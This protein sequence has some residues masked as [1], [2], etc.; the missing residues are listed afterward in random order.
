MRKDA[1]L[2]ELDYGKFRQS[3]RGLRNDR[4]F[5]QSGHRP[6]PTP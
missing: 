3:L 4:R 2:T 5:L 6:A 1:L